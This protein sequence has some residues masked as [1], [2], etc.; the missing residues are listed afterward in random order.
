MVT[1]MPDAI[2]TIFDAIHHRNGTEQH[3]QNTDAGQ[4]ARIGSKILQGL[5]HRLARC[6]HEVAEDKIEQGIARTLEY[7]ETENI[8]SAA[9]INGTNDTSVV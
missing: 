1:H 8:A 2:E 5:L 4:L 3:H 9:T 6:R 7:R